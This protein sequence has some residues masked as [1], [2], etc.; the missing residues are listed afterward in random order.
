[1]PNAYK[2]PSVSIHYLNIINNAL[3]RMGFQS[4]EIHALTG[5]Y[6]EQEYYFNRVPLATLKE[7]WQSAETITNDPIIGLHVG[8]KIH[9]HDYGLLGQIMM[10]C[11]NL[12]EA[13]EK[14]LSIEF[15]IN[16]IFVSEVIIKDDLAINRIHSQQY[17]AESI[18]HIIEQDISALINIGLFVMNKE[19]GEHNRPIE[20]HFRHKPAADVAEY[21]RILKTK[22]LF[23]QENN[24]AIFP[25]AI[26]EAP[27]Y[28]PNP[29][30]AKLLNIELQKLLH[31][32]ENQD[33]LTLRLWRYLQTQKS[34][35]TTDI[36]SIA[37]QFNITTRT[38]QR[39]LQQEGTSFQDEIK[40]FRTQQAKQLLNNKQLTICEIAFQMGFNDNSA[41]HKAF[42]RWTGL[43]PKEFRTTN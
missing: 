37:Q 8:E 18:R 12:E 15:I 10:N 1:M 42:K 19:Y 7:A 30:I 21:E 24:Q 31:E 5:Q 17:E 14:I 3:E 16:N 22:V 4:P 40:Y 32:V 23:E 41:F 35:F 43:T 36:E 39:R 6:S 28:N 20:I 25:L 38:L 2:H 29:Q 34:N 13:L 33:T 27:I 11:N 9:P 26:L